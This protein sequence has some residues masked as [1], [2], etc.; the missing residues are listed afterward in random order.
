MQERL[1][2]LNYLSGVADGVFGAE[3]QNAL[4]AFQTRNGLTAD[5]TAG[6]ST[7]KS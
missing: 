2:E 1:I 4:T 5:G 7:L 3:T 6:A